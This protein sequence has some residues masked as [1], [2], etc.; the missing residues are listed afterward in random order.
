M[1]PACVGGMV[2][3]YLTYFLGAGLV[4]DLVVGLVV[5]LVALL[6]VAKAEAAPG[7]SALCAPPAD[8]DQIAADLDSI[9]MDRD[10]WKQAAD[11]VVV[12]YGP[13]E[14]G[15]ASGRLVSRFIVEPRLRLDGPTPKII[16]I[17]DE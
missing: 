11:G 2:K 7:Q 10:H 13:R 8:M 1:K 6:G 4:I 3:R 5:G 12:I 17:P 9:V 14:P 15:W 16:C